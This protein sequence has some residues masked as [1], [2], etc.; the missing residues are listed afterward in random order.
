MSTN[1]LKF[2][3]RKEKASEAIIYIARRIPDPT[4]HSI[5]K[6]LYFA[7]KTSLERYGRFIFGETYVAMKHGP[8]PSNVYDMM[9]EAPDNG[10]F[11]FRTENDHDIVTSRDANVNELSDS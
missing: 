9:K 2:E 6:L 10:E 4:Y 5:S 8:V 3:F 1:K 7:D 11:G